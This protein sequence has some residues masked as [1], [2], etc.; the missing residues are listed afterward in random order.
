MNREIIGKEETEKSKCN[1]QVR[2]K[3]Q[4]NESHRY[5]KLR[6][7]LQVTETKKGERNLIKKFLI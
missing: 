5:M 6:E 4:R 1:G 7:E 3:A 2:M